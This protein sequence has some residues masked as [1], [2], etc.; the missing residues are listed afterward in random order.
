MDTEGRQ[1][2][3]A[4]THKEKL[5]E[6][7][8]G[9]TITAKKFKERNIIT[10]KNIDVHDINKNI[11]EVIRDNQE[12]N[13][14]IKKIIENSTKDDDDIVNMLQ[15]MVTEGK[16]KIDKLLN[17]LRAAVAPISRAELPIKS[18]EAEGAPPPNP[19]SRG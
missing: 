18:A 12:L 4:V 11:A 10:K 5:E 2:N 13:V 16:E 3:I 8:E 7:K 15:N 17:T 19:R 1:G 6:E 14:T 9:N